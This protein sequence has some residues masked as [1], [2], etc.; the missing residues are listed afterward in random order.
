MEDKLEKLE[1]INHDQNQLM[2]END[3]NHKDLFE[4]SEFNDE[5]K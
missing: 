5:I 3:E 2:Q 1:F 4:W